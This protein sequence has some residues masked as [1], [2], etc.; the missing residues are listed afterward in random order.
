MARLI[1]LLM[2]FAA[3]A[4]AVVAAVLLLRVLR[5]PLATPLPAPQ[6]EDAMPRTARNVAYALLILLLL[7]V[8]S[9]LLAGPAVP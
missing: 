1:L 9:G 2:L 6:T 5:L 7:G 4:L 3:L 8:T